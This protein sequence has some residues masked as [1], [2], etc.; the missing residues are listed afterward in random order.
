MRATIIHYVTPEGEGDWDADYTPIEAVCGASC[1]LDPDGEPDPSD[2]DF[3]MAP[4]PRQLTDCW[5]CLS[6]MSEPVEAREAVSA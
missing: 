4:D 3:V 1:V 2:F 6:K 5:A